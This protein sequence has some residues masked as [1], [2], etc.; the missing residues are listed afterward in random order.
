MTTE[1]RAHKAIGE[2][3][4]GKPICW[5]EKGWRCQVVSIGY[6]YQW[7]RRIIEREKSMTLGEVFDA[8]LDAHAGAN[9]DYGTE[10]DSW[11]SIFL[12]GKFRERMGWL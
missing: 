3:K 5:C 11:K 4:S 7:Q 8:L 12:E 2:T 1:G 10:Q 9:S 6:I